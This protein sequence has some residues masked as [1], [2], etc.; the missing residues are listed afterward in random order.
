MLYLS[1]ITAVVL[2]VSSL[3]ARAEPAC[4]ID[5]ARKQIIYDILCG[6]YAKEPEYKFSGMNCA[7]KSITQRLQDSSVQVVAYSRCGDTA[8]STRMKEANLK[9]LRVMEKLSI[10]TPE[11]IN[12]KVLFEGELQK[13]FEKAPT[14]CDSEMRKRLE[15]RRQYFG[16]MIATSNDTKAQDII[17]EHLGIAIDLAG[18]IRAK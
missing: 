16:Q 6:Q 13:T 15:S 4:E 10:C 5:Q 12:L 2:A 3:T 17:L 18:N 14:I 1:V 7:T 8:F 9:T 11:H